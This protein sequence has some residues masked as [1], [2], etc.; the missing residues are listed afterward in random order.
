[1]GARE[2]TRCNKVGGRPTADDDQ[3]HRNGQAGGADTL[4][5][6]Q[7]VSSLGRPPPPPTPRDAAGHHACPG[8]SPARC[9]ADRRRLDTLGGVVPAQVG[10]VC[11]RGGGCAPDGCKEP[12][13]VGRA[14]MAPCDLQP[15]R[16]W[17]RGLPRAERDLVYQ[18]REPTAHPSAPPATCRRASCARR[19][20]G[21]RAL[22]SAGLHRAAR[23]FRQGASGR[24]RRVHFHVGL[25]PPTPRRAVGVAVAA[26]R[27]TPARQPWARRGR[28]CAWRKTARNAAASRRRPLW[29]CRL[30]ASRGL[31]SPPTPRA[32][33]VG[34]VIFRGADLAAACRRLHLP[35]VRP[36]PRPLISSKTPRRRRRAPPRLVSL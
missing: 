16:A 20:L 23:R 28:S 33:I 21:H 2:R 8:P 10:G 17:R 12:R 26:R 15:W 31:C 5:L 14:L 22:R 18:P 25:Q 3:A 1:M 36:P 11:R 30:L 19:R 4:A 6:E 32:R 27:H 34:S 35:H 9:A 24:R 29:R 13:R 7:E